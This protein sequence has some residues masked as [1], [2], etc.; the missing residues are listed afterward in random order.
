MPLA[1][2]ALAVGAFAIGSGEFVMVG[3]LPKVASSFS[4]TIPQAGQLISTYALGI[5]VGAPLLIAVFVRF[6]PKALLIGFM[7]AFSFC[8]VLSA[9]APSYDWLLV[10]RFLSGLPHGAYFGVGAVA[11]RNM[12][13]PARRALAI[14]IMFTGLTLANVVGVPFITFLG[15]EVGWRS[16]FWV[17]AVI[18]LIAGL[19][20]LVAL[21]SQ[22]RPAEAPRLR[23]ELTAFRNMQVW[24]ALAMFTLC[25]GS[26]FAGYSYIATVMTRVTG[27]DERSVPLLLVL[28]GFGMTVGNL[29]GARMADRALMPSLYGFISIEAAMAGLFVVTSHNHVAGLSR[30][31]SSWPPALPS[32]LRFKAAS[33][34]GRAA[35]PMWPPDLRMP[36]A[37]RATP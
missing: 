5:V 24:L 22:A 17:I 10:A 29:V 19:S 32:P 16:V 8:N 6:P 13:G 23:S 35:R 27:F 20:V 33:S 11:A 7:L 36:P 34:H 12:V 31:A 4:V 14:S 30:S 37:P 1:L 3:L 28:F 2:T 18:G 15:Q 25:S 21:K 9:L 26:L